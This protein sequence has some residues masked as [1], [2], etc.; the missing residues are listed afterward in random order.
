MYTAYHENLYGRWCIVSGSYYAPH[1]NPSEF[2][3]FDNLD[4]STSANLPQALQASLNQARANIPPAHRDVPE[5]VVS[6]PDS[7]FIR[8]NDWAFLNGYAYVKISG[9]AK[10]GRYRFGCIFHSRKEGQRTQNTRNIDEKDRKRVNSYVRGIGCPVK[11][12]VSRDVYKSS[13]RRQI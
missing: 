13:L 5:G 1:T 8:I 10:E 12:T 2:V 11:I 7:A 4:M 6:N 9:S 3:T